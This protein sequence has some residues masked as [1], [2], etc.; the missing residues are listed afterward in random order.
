[1]RQQQLSTGPR[2]RFAGGLS[3]DL[4]PRSGRMVSVGGFGISRRSSRVHDRIRRA[5]TVL[6]VIAT[7]LVVVDAHLL[8]VLIAPS[9]WA[10]VLVCGSWW[11]SYAVAKDLTT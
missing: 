8:A 2:P 1:M 6:L 10:P 4:L 5:L 7:A 9:W 11:I 3:V